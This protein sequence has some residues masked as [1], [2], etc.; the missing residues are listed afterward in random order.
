M[1][2]WQRR[3]RWRM[4][5][6]YVL[7]R[8]RLCGTRRPHTKPGVLHPR[9]EGGRGLRGF[10]LRQ[11][12]ERQIR[13]VYLLFAPGQVPDHQELLHS[14]PLERGVVTDRILALLQQGVVP[15][16]K[17]GTTNDRSA[18]PVNLVAGRRSAFRVRRRAR[19]RLGPGDFL[20]SPSLPAGGGEAGREGVGGVRARAGAPG[21]VGGRRRIQSRPH[22][23]GHTRYFDS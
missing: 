19:G 9:T 13:R 2:P 15:W 11:L 17:P 12:R 23:P 18:A 5:F 16:K 7:R 3:L 21:G 14:I 1:W 6:E 20:Q 8:G 22:E 4:R 10:W